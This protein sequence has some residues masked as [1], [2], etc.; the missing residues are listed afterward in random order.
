MRR[1]YKNYFKRVLDAL[2]ALLLIVLLLPIFVILTVVGFFAYGESPFFMQERIGL[3]GN[4]FQI[5]KFKSMRR[6]LPG[7]FD[8]YELDKKRINA[9]GIFLRKTSLDEL[10]NLINVLLGSMSLI[11]PRPLLVKYLAHFSSEQMKRHRV[12]P[13][14]TGLAQIS[15]RNNLDWDTRLM[16]DV[17]YVKTLTLLN[18]VKI[19]LATFKA[20]VL[21]S[22]I[23]QDRDNTM[24]GFIAH[25]DR[26]KYLTK[27]KRYKS[28][29]YSVLSQ[30]EIDYLHMQT[31]NMFLEI[32][33]IFDSRNID[34]MI[35]GGTLL[36][37]YTKGKFIP[38]DDD[39]DMCI[40]SQDYETA[41]RALHELLPSEYAVQC[42][43][44]DSK[45]Y[46]G[47]MKVRDKKSH[48][49]PDAPAFEFNGVWVDI[50][51][52]VEAQKDEV[53]LKVAVEAK[54]YIERRYRSG[55]FTRE[56]YERR[57]IDDEV[58]IKIKK[59]EEAR[60]NNP[61]TDT[62]LII[63][64]ASKTVLD[65]QWVYPL[66]TTVFE[67]HVVKTFHDPHRYLTSHYGEGYATLPKDRDRTVGIN[68]IELLE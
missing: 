55:G 41:W 28:F 30:R 32:K 7:E 33:K 57:L 45:Y 60:N 2:I 14:V 34:Y 29:H 65:P 31:L 3:L 58:D 23:Q 26:S 52:L 35:C 15:G 40:L 19:L 39:F 48:V 4:K 5:I 22:G 66:S 9:Y 47:W 25:K 20:V 13:G 44:V 38:W 59:A 62:K 16:L 50:Y 61:N 46:L 37:A 51:C 21:A 8:N 42:P 49:Y 10:P 67:G 1:L 68:K 64:S 24:E 43:E 17:R 36:G 11:G 56:K 6:V 18:D 53:E 54:K 27:S 63:W 12:R